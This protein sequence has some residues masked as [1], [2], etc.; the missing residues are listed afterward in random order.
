[1]NEGVVPK[2]ETADFW[3]KQ[4]RLGRRAKNLISSWFQRKKIHNVGWTLSM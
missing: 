3:N 1:M 4:K 2:C